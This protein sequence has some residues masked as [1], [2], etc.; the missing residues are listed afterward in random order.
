M[1]GGKRGGRLGG[2]NWGGVR[3]GGGGGGGWG[4]GQDPG[5]GRGK[6][7]NRTMGGERKT[8]CRGGVKR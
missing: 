3:Q 6:G 7:G 1:E 8:C 2:D 4:W 5:R